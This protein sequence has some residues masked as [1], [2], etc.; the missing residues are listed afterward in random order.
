MSVASA[1]TYRELG[2]SRARRIGRKVG[3]LLLLLSAHD[4]E[5][6]ADAT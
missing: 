5:A 6:W 3:W 4:G 2:L 1:H